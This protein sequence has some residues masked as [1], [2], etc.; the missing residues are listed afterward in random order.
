MQDKDFNLVFSMGM[1]LGVMTIAA[2]MAEGFTCTQRGWEIMK[3]DRATQI[4]KASGM[5]A[6]DLQLSVQPVVDAM[7]KRF[8]D[9]RGGEL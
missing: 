8:N 5:P 3:S 7:V 6:E 4:E 1:D 9:L 2:L